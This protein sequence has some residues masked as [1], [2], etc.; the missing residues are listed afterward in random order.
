MEVLQGARNK[1]QQGRALRFLERLELVEL[2]QTDLEWATQQLIQFS[3][4]HNADA[5][6]CLIAAP[7]QRLNLPL[8]TRNL[9]HFAPLLPTLAQKPY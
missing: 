6:D 5:F 1:V 9:K 4:S 3:L 8:Y 2:T 7:C